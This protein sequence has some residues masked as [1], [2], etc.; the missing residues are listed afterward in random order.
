M[1][2]LIGAGDRQ[3]GED[4]SAVLTTYGAWQPGVNPIRRPAVVE[5]LVGALEEVRSSSGDGDVGSFYVGGSW[6]GEGPEME[7]GGGGGAGEGSGSSSSGGIGSDGGS[8][9]SSSSADGA[10]D[11]RGVLGVSASSSSSGAGG[12][13]SSFNESSS[14]KSAATTRSDS[15][16]SG[17]RSGHNGLL[18]DIGAGHGFFSLAAAAAGHKVIA[19]EAS[20]LSLAALKAS[21]AY[22]GFQD[23]IQLREAT[24]GTQEGW[25]CLGGGDTEEVAT[26]GRQEYDMGAAGSGAGRAADGVDGGKSNGAG[27]AGS[28]GRGQQQQGQ[29]ER[30]YVGDGLSST[31]S[32]LHQLSPGVLSNLHLHKGNEALLLES[33]VRLRRGYPHVGD[34]IGGHGGG[35]GGL[36][37]ATAGGGG[38]AS[39]RVLADGGGSSASGKG[40]S[41]GSG[42]GS[43]EES[44]A[45]AAVGGDDLGGYFMGPPGFI[46]EAQAGKGGSAC[47][48][49]AKKRV[50]TLSKLLGNNTDVSVLRLSVHGHEGW[51]L[52][53]ALDWLQGVHKPG[54]I[55]LEF[56]PAAMRAAGYSQPAQVLWQLYQLGYKDAAH[57]GQ[58]CDR[59]WRDLTSLLHWQVRRW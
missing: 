18:V 6:S 48:L 33:G 56:W 43:L 49:G 31:S 17:S 41:S 40:S 34:L 37:A 11:E 3:G 2:H 36:A 52:E 20:P 16:G 1:T 42:V 53:G 50:T 45:A 51:V 9:S 46:S 12:G 44:L 32:L 21:V 15:S 23:R 4:V 22:N 7:E 38:G 27:G 47:P 30:G 5:S 25:V 19:A 35:A 8:S 10:I 13:G 26:G 58:V 54:V 59:R 29:D 28:N 24:L 55:H 39:A 57:A 14:I